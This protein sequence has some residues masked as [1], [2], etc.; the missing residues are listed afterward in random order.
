MSE[1]I[2]SMYSASA[3]FLEAL[4]EAGVLYIFANFGSDHP[5]LIEALAEA[6]AT[7]RPSP[8]PI[9]CPNEMVALS[10]AQGYAQLSGQAQAVLVHVDCGTQALGG[11]LHNAARNRAP[12]L[13]FAG[14]SPATQEGEIKGSRNEFIHWLQDAGDQRGIV[15]GYVKFNHE[16]RAGANI[17][18]NVHRA[19]QIATSDPKGPV[20]LTAAREVM[21]Q[22]VEAVAIDPTRWRSSAQMPLPE[23]SVAEISEALS[24]ARAPVIVTSYLG[25]NPAAVGALEALCQSV[26]VGVIES[27]PST[28]NLPVDSDFYLGSQWN[29]PFRTPALAQA[30]VI[31]VIDSDIPWIGTV[32]PAAAEATIYH[33]DVDP[34]KEAIPL[35]YIGA[36]RS[37]RAD[38]ATALAQ[39]NAHLSV[40]PPPMERVAERTRR[41]AE[42]H[43]VRAATLAQKENPARGLSPEL[44][45]ASVGRH[46][47]E[48]AV[49]L[50][51]GV[52][53]YP[54]IRHHSG[55]NKP[56][57]YFASGGSSLG[58]S[59]GAAIGMKLASPERLVVALT[60][61][62]SYLF[63][64]PS[65]VHWMA[66][67]YRTPF[68]QI[69]YNNG[70][71][72]AP[73][74]SALAIHP[75]GYAAKANDLGLDFVDPE[76][77]YAAIAAAAGG[78][79]ARTVTS[80][81]ELEGALAEGV[82][83]VREEKRC[84]V[85]D[86]KLARGGA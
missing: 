16:I 20:Y 32:N 7:G 30:D 71:W 58:W 60:G 31:L 56:G 69:I 28:M 62:G 75:Q 43:A 21:E 46:I 9:T 70:G 52:T 12:V 59:G 77:N 76:P 65:T 81:E 74:F 4:H 29:E 49:V 55:R 57:A 73:R 35:W 72:R 86:V 44:L 48:D 22:E 18:Q 85:I 40:H 67:H 2:E 61:D 24:R 80:L 3:A 27:A 17:K 11:A 45:T 79:H 6:R 63:S 78:A 51:E 64:A 26:G 66:A 25:R 82:R 34:L 50:S 14:M 19:L 37:F 39:L 23:D 83:V 41:Y 54:V 1:E 42:M 68:L 5:A 10:C 84:A 13:I 53:N 38:A 15:R 36:H 33:I 8:T 47:G